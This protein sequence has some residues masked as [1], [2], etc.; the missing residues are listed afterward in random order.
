[1]AAEKEA[2]SIPE[3]MLPPN[4]SMLRACSVA[5]LP[6]E[7]PGTGSSKQTTASRTLKPS[8]R[9]ETSADR[10]SSKVEP[11]PLRGG[12]WRE[13]QAE[14]GIEANAGVATKGV[15]KWS[16]T[17]ASAMASTGAPTMCAARSLAA[18]SAQGLWLRLPQAPAE[19]MPS[20]QVGARA[21]EGTTAPTLLSSGTL[22]I[23]CWATRR[24]SRAVSSSRR[25]ASRLGKPPAPPAPTPLESSEL[26]ATHR[27][28]N[29]SISLHNSPRLAVMKGATL[30]ALDLTSPAMD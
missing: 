16:L 15:C 2:A 10:D 26:C 17:E 14:A 24:A 8:A 9:T 13:E 23:S 3:P 6:A 5:T 1:M 28:F 7:A 29:V 20:S 27:S 30:T 19:A 11:G 22:L 18:F 21:G 12:N 4:A 25:A